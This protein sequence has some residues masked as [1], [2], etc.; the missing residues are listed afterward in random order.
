MDPNT[1]QPI[2]TTPVQQPVA[3]PVVPTETTPAAPSPASTISPEAPKGKNGKIIIL[4][5][6]LLLLV[7]GIVTYVLFARAQMNNAQK[8]TTE[9]KSLVLPTPTTIP[10]LTPEEDL[11]VS[12]PD[13]DLIDIETDVKGL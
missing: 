12:S 13:E 1:N 5:V 3:Q 7:V 9:N 11:E 6:I 10:T 8:T 2:G 4:L